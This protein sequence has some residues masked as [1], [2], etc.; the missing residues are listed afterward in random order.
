MKEQSG[1]LS[2]QKNFIFFLIV[3]LPVSQKILAQNFPFSAGARSWGIGNA[4]VAESGYMS[5][6]ANIAGLG[7]L[8]E[9]VA[10]STYDS[11]FGFDGLSTLGFGAVLPVSEDLTTGF[12]I[13]RFGDKLY[14]ELAIGMG[15][16]HRI[17][18][19]SL[20]L[21]INYLQNAVNAPSLII[22]RKALA[23]EFG[24]IV[25]FTSDFSFGAHIF[26]MTQSSYS[27][28]FGNKVPT[29]LRAGF[30]YKPQKN[31]YLSAEVDKNTDLPFSVKAG[32]EYQ[33]WRNL[34]LRT[35]LSSRPLANHFGAGFKG[36]KFYVDYAVHTHPQLGWSH[37]FSLGYSLWK[38]KL[39]EKS[40]ENIN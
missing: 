27:G 4:T 7:G 38:S 28:D 35:G 36:G 22:S 33:I 11:H 21:K 12:T 31:V 3:L 20:G 18:R 8:R 5:G 30:L 13:A 25:Q 17:G 9:S 39:A 14:N 29:V 10:F 24:G 23:F 26:N 15:A 1:Y 19:V 34:Y 16:G 6:S 2:R 37:H 40:S 32:L